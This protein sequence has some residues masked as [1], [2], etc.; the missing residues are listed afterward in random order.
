MKV[1]KCL[2][3]V[4]LAGIPLTMVCAPPENNNAVHVLFGLD[5]PEKG[6][7]PSDIFAVAD[8]AQ[9]TGLRVNLPPPDCAVRASDCADLALINVL[10]GFNLQPRV[11]VPF[12]GN[13]DPTSVNSKNALFVEL[14][15]ADVDAT[16]THGETRTP[17]VIGVNQLVWDPAL[18]VLA[19]ESDEQLRQH[20]RY[21]F[22]I[23]TGIRD[24]SG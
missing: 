15:N 12:D 9:K 4:L 3:V 6:I 2:I 22:V 18:R 19:A 8:D 17:H 5:D 21:G 10:D 24:T 23:T 1:V 14:G 11:T 7:F 13:I 16:A 20:T